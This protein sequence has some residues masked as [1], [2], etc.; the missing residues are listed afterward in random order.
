MVSERHA[1]QS[2]DV[3]H[4][5]THS[6]GTEEPLAG[7]SASPDGPSVWPFCPAG[8]PASGAHRSLAQFCTSSLAGGW[9]GRRISSPKIKLTLSS[10]LAVLPP[11]R[12][13]GPRQSNRS[14]AEP[15]KDGDVQSPPVSTGGAPLFCRSERA[16]GLQ[17]GES[18]L[19]YLQWS[20]WRSR[21]SQDSAGRHV[22]ARRDDPPQSPALRYVTTP[23]GKTTVFCDGWRGARS[24]LPLLA[25]PEQ[26]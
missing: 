25:G 9:T 17:D 8:R 19:F 12:E 6:G 18:R 3:A 21:S 7:A 15:I 1:A 23:T 16:R 2:V 20:D 14:R 22:C 24:R 10:R 5:Q 13:K 11:K 4:T 26:Q